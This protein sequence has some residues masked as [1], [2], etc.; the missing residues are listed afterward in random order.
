MMKRVI[1]T[2]PVEQHVGSRALQVHR[3]IRGGADA[4]VADAD[5][6]S[7]RGEI[8]VDALLVGNEAADLELA[9]AGRADE[10]LYF[11]TVLIEDQRAVEFADAVRQVVERDGY[12]GK[13]H[14]TGQRRLGQSPGCVDVEV[15]VSRTK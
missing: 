6:F 11:K 3:G 13:A 5:I 15:H 10:I 4:G 14:L 8:S 1:C 12:V 9:A 7:G 2:L